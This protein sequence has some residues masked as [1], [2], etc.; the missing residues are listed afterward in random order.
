MTSDR[1]TAR[2]RRY[3]EILADP[4]ERRTQEE[5]AEELGV[6]RQT[7]WNWRQLEGFQKEIRRLVRDHTDQALARVWGS[8]LRQ[9][10]RG[11]VP[12]MRL[13]FQLRGEL[14]DR[15]EVEV[16]EPPKTVVFKS[17]VVGEEDG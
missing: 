7:L 14:I 6:K 17:T 9:S 13:Y 3:M 4:E 10:K 1:W 2:Q 8:L 5:I 12:A 16:R 15:R 11:D